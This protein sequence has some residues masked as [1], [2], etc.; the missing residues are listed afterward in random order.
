MFEYH[1]KC[2]HYI[3]LLLHYSITSIHISIKSWPC[4]LEKT[5]KRLPSNINLGPT[6]LKCIKLEVVYERSIY[7][8]NH[9]LIYF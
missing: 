9:L 5:L 4:T 7:K 8:K 2:V 6:L 1:G 3:E